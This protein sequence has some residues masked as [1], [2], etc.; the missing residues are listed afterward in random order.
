MG[1]V[2]GAETD[3]GYSTWGK[4][5]TPLLG[6]Y[7]AW[8]TY[9]GSLTY[10][11]NYEI[12]S[13]FH[14]DEGLFVRC[15]RW[16]QAIFW[17]DSGSSTHTEYDGPVVGYMDGGGTSS[18]FSIGGY[19]WSGNDTTNPVYTSANNL[20]DQGDIDNGFVGLTVTYTSGTFAIDANALLS[21][22]STTPWFGQD[23]GINSITSVSAIDTFTAF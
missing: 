6:D 16:P 12:D 3:Q 10:P 15:D 5:R 11:H 7:N 8:S 17:L 22:P 2:I 14:A 4:L 18:Y 19:D 9:T 1:Y 23:I 13:G 21:N 20:L